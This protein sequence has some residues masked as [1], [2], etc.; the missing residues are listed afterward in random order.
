MVELEGSEITPWQKA[1]CALGCAL[2]IRG[3]QMNPRAVAQ[4]ASAPAL[5]A[6][7]RGFESHQPDHAGIV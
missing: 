1:Q 5:G 3:L 4:L 2:P 6:G 7:G